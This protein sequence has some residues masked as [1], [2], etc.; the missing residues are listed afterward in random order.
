MMILT[1]MMM[2]MMNIENYIRELL[3][4][5]YAHLIPEIPINMMVNMNQL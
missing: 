5:R 1:M 3:R 4:G 2:M